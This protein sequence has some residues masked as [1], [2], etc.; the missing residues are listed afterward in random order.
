MDIK[1]IKKLLCDAQDCL[2]ECPNEGYSEREKEFHRQLDMAYD[3]I[4][5]ALS[6]LCDGMFEEDE[7]DDVA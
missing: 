6:L 5:T 4:G 1:D 7:P 3:L 2:T